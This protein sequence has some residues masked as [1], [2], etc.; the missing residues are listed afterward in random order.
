MWKGRKATFRYVRGAHTLKPSSEKLFPDTSL[1]RNFRSDCV[2]HHGAASAMPESAKIDVRD[3]QSRAV[4]EEFSQ[5]QGE[6]AAES[7]CGQKKQL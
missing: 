6:G 1:R 2:R 5:L 4:L 7:I 3:L